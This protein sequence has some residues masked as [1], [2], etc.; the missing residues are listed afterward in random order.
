[1][2]VTISPPSDFK[3]ADE[4]VGNSLRSPFGN[5]PAGNVCQRGEHQTECRRSAACRAAA[6]ACADTPA[7]S[8]RVVSSAKA[9]RTR[10]SA[11]LSARNPK[12]ATARGCRGHRGGPR[13]ASS[14]KGHGIDDA[15]DHAA[16]R[17]GRRAETVRGLFDRPIDGRRSRPSS[18][19]CASIT[20]GSSHLSPNCSSGSVRKNG[21]AA[22]KGE[23]PSR[24]RARIP[25]TSAQRIGAAAGDRFGLEHDDLAAGSSQHD[26]RCQTVRSGT[27][28]H[29]VERAHKVSIRVASFSPGRF[30]PDALS[31]YALSRLIFERSLALI[32]LIAFLCAANQFVPLLGEHGLLP[33]SRY[34]APGAVRS[35]AQP[36]LFRANR[37]SVSHRRVARASPYQPGCSLA[38]LQRTALVAAAARGRRC[39]CCICRSSTSDRSSTGSG[40]SRCCSKPGFFAIFL[41]ASTTAPSA[42]LIWIWRWVLFRDMFGAGL[43]K[44][45]GDACWRD[46]TCLNYYFETQPMPN[47][48]SWY[49]HWLPAGVHRAGVAFNH[50]AE[51]LVPFGIFRSAAD[52]RHRRAHDHRLSA[53]AH[54]ERQSIVAELDDDR[55]V[56]SHAR[57]SLVCRGCR[58]RRRHSRCHRSSNASAIYAVAVLVAILSVRPI[59]NMLSPR[60]LMNF[61]FNPVHLVNTYGAFG[62]ITRTRNEIVIEGTDAAGHHTVDHL[63]RV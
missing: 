11:E 35:H 49:F 25:G 59:V 23:R 63:A 18:N 55:A 8:A 3:I 13:M 30:M 1:M 29:G 16:G 43:I 32:Y 12:R 41:G 39:G 42:F 60:Q 44:L 9:R 24:H 45:R 51:L 10:C 62:S 37:P 61:S 6:C 19:G 36:L 52:R 38:S 50:V 15:A 4:R 22:R 5:H 17:L 26:R 33:V 7:M 14:N 56:H 48:L 46:L 27:N 20:A 57:R 53:L 47:A 21:E 31:G 28:D 34:R 40:G 2:P 58:C 54:R